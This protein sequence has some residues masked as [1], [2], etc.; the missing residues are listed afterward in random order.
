MRAVE[1]YAEGWVAQMRLP[2]EDAAARQ[3]AY[4]EALARMQSEVE[5]QMAK[6]GYYV[7]F[8]PVR[9]AVAQKTG[10]GRGGMDDA[11]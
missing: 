8:G 1:L 5:V 10:M 2:E 4:R 11:P 6:Q 7:P 3:A 9:M